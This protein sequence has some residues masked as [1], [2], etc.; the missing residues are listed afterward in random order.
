MKKSYLFLLGASLT[1]LVACGPSAEEKAADQKRID[2]SVAAA[3]SAMKAA[4]EAAM[5]AMAADTMAADTNAAVDTAHAGHD[6]AH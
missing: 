4:E 3:E 1:F 5:A 2:D 6:H